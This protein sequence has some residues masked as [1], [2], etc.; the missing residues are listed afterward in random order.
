MAI[1][2]E[3]LA[4]LYDVSRE[5]QDRLAWESQQ[6]AAAA[7]RS[8]YLSQEVVPVEGHDSRGRPTLVNQDEHVRPDTTM[9]A[10]ARLPARFIPDGGTVTA[11]SAS[12]IVDGAAALLVTST[13]RAK[14]EGW[15]P[16]ARL[17][18]TVLMEMQ[19]RQE[20]HGVASMCIG[21]G[22]GAAGIFELIQ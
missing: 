14:A 6:R 21:G 12:G 8:G 9:E 5:E 1:T 4:R 11:G 13:V 7:W 15:T 20:R 18:L 3:N 17:V 2:A 19:R 10:L 16:V 22:M